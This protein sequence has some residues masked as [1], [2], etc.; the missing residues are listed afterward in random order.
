MKKLMTKHTLWTLEEPAGGEAGG[1]SMKELFMSLF[2]LQVP[3]T[4]NWSELEVQG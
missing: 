3:R 4:Q 2:I 1:W